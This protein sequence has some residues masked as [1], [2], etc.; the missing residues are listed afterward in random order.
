MIGWIA[1]AAGLLAIA[2]VAHRISRRLLGEARPGT[3]TQRQAL[4]EAE[5]LTRNKNP[6][7]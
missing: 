2:Y 1:L 3:Q 6:G 4:D 5:V 7:L